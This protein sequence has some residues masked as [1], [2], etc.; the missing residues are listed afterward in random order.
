MGEAGPAVPSAIAGTD[1]LDLFR[2]ARL[3]IRYRLRS[4]RYAFRV[5]GRGRTTSF[6]IL[7]G[8]FT[9]LA[10][11]GL[12]AQAFSIIARTVGMPGQLA[13]LT[14]VTTTI[15]FGS[16]TARA[17]SNEAVRAGS[18]E[19]EFLLAR[20]VSLG[21]LVAARGLADAVTDP[22][23]AL[24]LLPVLISAASVWNLGPA[25]WLLS[26]AISLLMQIGI[27]MLAYTVQLAVVRW[28]P[29]RRR[30][31]VWTCLRLGAALSLAMIWML[32]TA[33]MR[34]PAALATGVDAIAPALT[35]SPAVLAG[36]PLAALARGDVGVAAAA[37]GL[38]ALA[39]AG[40]VVLVI[41]VARRAGM[42]GWEE[43]GAVWADTARTPRLTDRLPSAATKDLRLIVRD[44]SQLLALI[45]MPVIFI[46][47]Q[48]FGAAG[49]SWTTGNLD[50]ISCLAFSLALYMGTIG[51]LTHMQAERRAFWILRTVPVPL[52]H[53][54]AGKARAWAII[55]GG[56][57][58][59]AFAVLSVSVPNVDLVDR[60]MAGLLVTAGAAGI[61]FVAVAMA[62]GGADLSDE[63]NT[64]VGP[65]TVYAYLVVG[66]LFNVVLLGNA[67]TRIAGLVLYALAG[68]AYWQAGVEQA[69]FCL[70][71]EAVRTR[72][73]RA[74]D[75]ATMLIVYALGSWAATEAMRKAGVPQAAIANTRIGLLAL[76]VAAAAVY[77][78]R[79]PARAGTVARRGLPLSLLLGAGVGAAAGEL[80]AAVAGTVA[81]F[82][83]HAVALTADEIVLRGVVQRGLAEH[84]SDSS[85]SSSAKSRF[86]AALLAFVAGIVTAQIAGWSGVRAPAGIALIVAGH[87]AAAG[88]YALTGRVAAAWL[89]RVV[90]V[91]IAA[92]V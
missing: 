70:D 82:S 92:F 49:W 31:M 26:A 54:L 76:I 71:A 68:W 39:A 14:L 89:S 13:A 43:A 83:W 74:A 90:T 48:I 30:R 20:P 91:G 55:I 52:G 37:L 75:G 85:S 6:A 79:R 21:A 80:V 1:R 60:L 33:V 27:L 58:A 4:M 47:V 25:G 59:A 2:L 24:F 72:S 16:L 73:V 23:G 63:T 77:L 69:E 50:R 17:A 40:T 45:G 88:V 41:A 19:N 3:F 38:L 9:S 56:I 11:V 64:A 29:V 84:K 57:A 12:F 22:V 66:G 36:A 8:V 51:P 5:R 87:A 18:P 10:Y 78:A 35:Y 42:T 62:S 15:A 61:S 67:A 44:R 7:V 34:A 65:G 46:G 86:R 28:V 32:G 53:L 81:G